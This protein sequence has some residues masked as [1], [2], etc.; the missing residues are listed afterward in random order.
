MF[1]LQFS[2]ARYIDTPDQLD[3]LVERLSHEK[4]IG[5]D[6]ESNSL[7]AYKEQVCLIQISTRHEDFLID[8][9]KIQQ[10]SALHHVFADPKIEKVFHAAEYDIMC[11]KRDFAYEITNLFDTMIAA[12]ICGIKQIG[13]SN[14]LHQYLGVRLDK[15]HQRDNWGE[16][17]LHFASLH[18]AQADVHYLPQLRDMLHMELQSGGYLEE[19]LEVFQELV[20]IPPHDGRTFDP[21]GFWKIGIPN[22]L[23]PSEMAVLREVYLIREEAAKQFNMPPFKIF[24]TQTLIEFARDKPTSLGDLTKLTGMSPAQIRRY[25]KQILA[26]V[27]RARGV[28]L[29][30]PPQFQPPP[31]LINDRYVALHAW[32]KERAVQRGVESDVIISKQALWELAEKLPATVEEMA[33]IHGIGPWR[34]KTYGEELMQVLNP[35]RSA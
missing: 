23:T 31:P 24:S 4:L 18:Y 9:L 17:P 25:G 35:F 6:T 1:D 30:P 7:H 21:D 12:R 19:A 32:R 15:S 34:L 5:I 8:P 11:L 28:Q 3:Q 27:Q 20:T 10:M 29:P 26:A 14:L 2:P 13:L 22:N 33:Q 16:R